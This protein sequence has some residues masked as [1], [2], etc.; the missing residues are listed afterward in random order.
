LVRGHRTINTSLVIALTHLAGS[1]NALSD[2]FSSLPSEEAIE[3]DRVRLALRGSNNDAFAVGARSL[4]FLQNRV[5]ELR[6]SAVLE[7]GSGHSTV[8]L[9]R[10]MKDLYSEDGRVRIFS[11][12]EN[13]DWLD[14]TRSLLRSADL[15]DR[16]KLAQCSLREQT[17]GSH[18]SLCYDL[19]D[20]FLGDFLTESPDFVLIDGPSGGGNARLA[21]LPRVLPYLASPSTVFLD[22]AFRTDEVRVISMW[23]ALTDIEFQGVHPL[24][25]GVLEARLG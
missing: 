9:A 20:D 4:N 23:Q 12:D 19:H 24:G 1:K 14:F 10:A 13:G 11:I 15:E 5:L 8:V 3:D 22:D 25:H 16:V 18:V 17:I 21:T 7:L 2:Y 6:P